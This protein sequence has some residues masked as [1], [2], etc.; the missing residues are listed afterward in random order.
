MWDLV[1]LTSDSFGAKSRKKVL[2][3]GI[4]L[5]AQVKRLFL[6]LFGG[7][8]VS[9]KAFL[10]FVEQQKTVVPGTEGVLGA[11][12]KATEHG[13][14]LGIAGSGLGDVASG[15]SSLSYGVE[16]VILTG[17]E[18]DDRRSK[19]FSREANEFRAAEIHVQDWFENRFEF[20]EFPAKF[21][22]V[23]SQFGG[24]L[25]SGFFSG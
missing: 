25:A 21:F 14:S 22:P 4:C 24:E 20:V 17:I 23:F 9:G 7:W 5:M 8:T 16:L 13:N 6:E 1:Y 15:F 11:L 3:D 10:R 2:C 12:E 19:P 18:M